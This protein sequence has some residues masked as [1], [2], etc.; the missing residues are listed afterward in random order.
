LE[1]ARRIESLGA[2][3]WLLSSVFVYAYIEPRRR[4]FRDQPLL[5]PGVTD[6]HL[7]IWYFEDWLKK[8]FFSYLQ[9]L[10]VS[11]QALFYVARC[12]SSLRPSPWIP[13]HM[14]ACSP[15]L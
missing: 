7:I 1:A 11:Q 4:Y 10:E 2:S 15:L 9:I 6:Q 8:Y 3:R 14:F 5:H 13:S 12:S